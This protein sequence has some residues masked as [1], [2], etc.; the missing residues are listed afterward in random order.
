MKF[1]GR[2]EAVGLRCRAPR[3]ARGLKY[4]FFDFALRPFFQSR[5]ARGAWIEI[6]MAAKRALM[7]SK[8][9]PARGAWIEITRPEPYGGA[10][11][12]APREGRVD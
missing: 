6:E 9:R 5:P 11:Y 12:V 1:E 7:T 2:A 8:S 3:G 4:N 10:D